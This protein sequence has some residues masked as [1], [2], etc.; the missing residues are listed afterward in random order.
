MNSVK[1]NR[2]EN[3]YKYF[4]RIDEY[5]FNLLVFILKPIVKPLYNKY[6]TFKKYSI[7]KQNCIK[8]DLL[9]KILIISVTCVLG[10][11][12]AFTVSAFSGNVKAENNELL[13]KYYTFYTVEPGD[14]LWEV[15]DSY[16]ELGYENHSDYIEEVMFINHLKDADDIISGETLVIPYY[17]YDIK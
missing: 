1:I 5:I 4:K 7:H 11:I 12:I 9:R 14:N 10:V 17:S 6:R 15:A 3:F 2:Q 13:H 16:Y 8:K